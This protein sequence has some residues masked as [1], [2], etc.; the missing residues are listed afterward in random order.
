[1]FFP[2][3]MS[4]TSWKVRYHLY[5]VYEHKIIVYMLFMDNIWVVKEQNFTRQ[6]QKP[7]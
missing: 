3:Q 2:G 5:S 6:W 1:M 4:K 7:T